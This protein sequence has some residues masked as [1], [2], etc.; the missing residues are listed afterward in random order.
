MKS[1]VDV[2][3]MLMHTEVVRTSDDS[4]AESIAVAGKLIEMLRAVTL[5]D[6]DWATAVETS[7]ADDKSEVADKVKEFLVTIRDGAHV[8]SIHDF[9]K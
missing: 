6:A 1:L 7:L 2:Y 5:D 9:L 8:N 4:S 3:H